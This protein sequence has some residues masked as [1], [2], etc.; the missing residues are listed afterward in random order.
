MTQPPIPQAEN[1]PWWRFPIV[2]MVIAGPALVVVAGLTTVVIAVKNVDPVL[3]TSQGQ[4]KGVIDMPAV[5]ARNHA[6]NADARA[7]ADR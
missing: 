2:W 7:P 1:K 6:A 3:D 5:Q 4:V